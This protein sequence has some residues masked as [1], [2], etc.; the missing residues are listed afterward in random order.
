MVRFARRRVAVLIV[1]VGFLVAGAGSYGLV[2]AAGPTN[3]SARLSQL[4]AGHAPRVNSRGLARGNAGAPDLAA[5]SIAEPFGVGFWNRTRGLLVLTSLSPGCGDG[6]GPCQGGSIERTRDGGRRWQV[7]YRLAAPVDAVSVA[8]RDVAW[9]TIGPVWCVPPDGCASRRLLVSSDGG[10][11]WRHVASSRAVASVSAVSSSDAWAVAVHSGSPTDST[12]LVRTTDGGRSWRTEV[13]P[14]PQS[15]PSGLAAV[16]FQSSTRGWVVCTSEAARDFQGKTMFWTANAGATWH[17][18]S[19]CQLQPEVV[20]G[21]ISCVGYLPRF[22]MLRDGHGWLWTAREGLSSTA[23]NGLKWNYLARNV[24][25]D[26]Q[27]DVLSASLISDS[28]GFMLIDQPEHRCPTSGC[29]PELL[30]TRDAGMRWTRLKI[31]PRRP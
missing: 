29:G 7:V 11:V 16:S 31:W 1:A 12:S 26:D 28:D 23:D 19:E 2:Q 8:R 24:V 4:S 5:H 15:Q 13:D 17:L 25:F 21:S 30:G 3:H 9:V 18:R 10:R 22:Q 27:N 6:S 20:L 14:C